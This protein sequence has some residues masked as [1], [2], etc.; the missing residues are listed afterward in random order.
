[1]S[2]SRIL[3]ILG[4]DLVHSP[5]SFHF[6]QAVITPLLCTLMVYMLFGSVLSGKPS[7]GFV[8]DGETEIS[9]LIQ[10]LEFLRF[11]EYESIDTLKAAVLSGK[12]DLG[13]SIPTG[14]DQDVRKGG[15][16]YLKSYIWGES[17]MKDRAVIFAGLSDVLVELAGKEVRVDVKTITLGNGESKPIGQRFL[18]LLVLLAI[19]MSGLLIPASAIVDEKQRQT[20]TAVT[21]T[22]AS[23]E[24]V[25]VAKSLLGFIMSFVMGVL[26]LVLN[27]S[28]G[29]NPGLLFLTLAMAAAFASAFG[30]LAG[31]LLKSL[32]GLT[33]FGKS[34]ILIIYG[35]GIL[36]LFPRIPQWIAKV[37]P[38]YYIFNPVLEVTQNNAG[39][40]DIG[41]ELIILAILIMTL[42]V[43]VFFVGKHK[44]L[45]IA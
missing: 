38:T 9:D 13:V 41:I 15:P 7:I 25:V 44:K 42:T 24:E 26:I 35:P 36:S 3:T 32:I 39:L 27:N 45:Q 14:F 28:F 1:M 43:I 22:P 2:A 19:M 29:A 34:L 20:L 11:S 21:V 5:K 33:N 40:T 8:F 10:K 16:A 30:A 23:F 18:P 12:L 17:L 4:K 31:V 37:F 6:I